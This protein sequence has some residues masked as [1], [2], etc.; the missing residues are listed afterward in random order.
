MEEVI[1]RIIEIDSMEQE[2]VSNAE[3]VKGNVEETIA[4]RKSELKSQYLDRAKKRIETLRE[5]ETNNAAE[6]VREQTKFN[7]EKI[8]QMN[9][10]YNKNSKKWAEEIFKR[11]IENITD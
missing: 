2:I 7:E 10:T 1:N 4:N 5:A 6:T 11:V 9:E 8:A 3:K